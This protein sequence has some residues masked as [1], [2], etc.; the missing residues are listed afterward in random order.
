MTE[1]FIALAILV[2]VMVLFV[3][4]T[5]PM[6]VTAMLGAMAMAVFG[7]IDYKQAFAGFANDSLMLVVGL[8]IVA[9]AIYESGVLGKIKGVLEK[10]AAMSDGVASAAFSVITGVLSGFFSN[11][12]MSA[13]G[14]QIV[15]STV[16][17]DPE[18]AARRKMAL[19]MPIGAAAVLGGNLSLAGSTPQLVAQG[20]LQ[21]AGLETMGF[22]TIAAG[23][24]PLFI[25]GLVYYSTIGRVLLA[26][27]KPGK[28]ALAEEEPKSGE[29]IDAP[30]S[31]RN[32]VI[33]VAV[34]AFC[35]AGFVTGIWT[36]GTVAIVGAL[37][38]LVTRCISMKTI[39]QK[40]DWSTI[41]ILG[42]SL[43]FC[44]GL[45]ESGAGEMIAN[46][47]IGLCGGDEANPLVLMAA[48]CALTCVVSNLM[49]NTASAAM[50]VPMG[51][52]LAQAMGINP[53]AMAIAIVYATSFCLFTPI[54]T[55]PMT[56]TLSGGYRFADYIKVGLPL[57]VILIAATVVIVPLVYGL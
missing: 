29:V 50:M 51:V 45:E 18:K 14:L 26:R 11:T 16:S 22:F 3:T 9:Q 10:F 12:A 32:M 13:L 36:M 37:I 1:A 34:F 23:G 31:T 28:N 46:F 6:P 56:L 20:V 8:L 7:V 30:A 40:L 54:G 5:I 52:F 53:F 4:E 17:G 43:G 19:F 42:G 27:C 35:V 38:L 33:S 15:G 57:A 41:V 21:E 25:I 49:A 47:I 39:V 24:I 44:V 2:V 48:M 55:V